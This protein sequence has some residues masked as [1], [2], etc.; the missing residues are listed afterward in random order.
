[1]IF[2]C[3]PFFSDHSNLDDVKPSVV[4]NGESSRD[5][6]KPMPASKKKRKSSDEKFLEDNSEYYGFQVSNG[7]VFV[8]FCSV[9]PGW[10]KAYNH[11]FLC[12]NL[13]SDDETKLVMVLRRFFQTNFAMPHLLV[14]PAPS[15]RTFCWTP[16]GGCKWFLQRVEMATRVA[17]R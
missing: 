9:E 5:Y 8:F 15:W 6:Q 14:P 16:N 4:C 12:K 1:M 13:P 7:H 17:M 3:I 2:I 11:F 10:S